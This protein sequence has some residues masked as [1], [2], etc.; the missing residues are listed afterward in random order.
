MKMRKLLILLF[1]ILVSFNSY[2]EVELDFSLDTFCDQSPKVEVREGLFYLPNAEK[3]YSGENICIYL[4]N[5]QYYSFGFYKNGVAVGQWNYWHDNGQ[6]QYE[7]SYK[8]GKY[9]GKWTEWFENGEIKSKKNYKGNQIEQQKNYQNGELFNSIFYSYYDNGQKQY[10]VS[11]KDGKYDGKWTYWYRNGQKNSEGNF[12]D[13]KK[14]DKWTEWHENGQKW[15]EGNYK[16][17]KANGNFIVFS[18]DGNKMTERT[19]KDGV[20]ISGNC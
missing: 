16:D 9:D 1:S 14:E 11:Y 19:F 2:G 18:K 10:V 8:D 12:I 20:C 15:L 6:K 7:V 3:P 4:I 17:G 5:G 13:S